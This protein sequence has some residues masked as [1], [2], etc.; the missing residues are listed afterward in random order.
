MAKGVITAETL[1]G[2]IVFPNPQELAD[3]LNFFL[4]YNQQFDAEYQEK[5]YFEHHSGSEDHFKQLLQKQAQQASSE[6]Y[7][8]LVQAPQT[9]IDGVE[10]AIIYQEGLQHC[11]KFIDRLIAAQKSKQEE[12]T[13]HSHFLIQNQIY[14]FCNYL[15]L[16]EQEKTK[17]QLVFG[18]DIKLSRDGYLKYLNMTQY[19]LNQLQHDPNQVNALLNMRMLYR[20]FCR[21]LVFY[22]QKELVI[23]V[24][25]QKILFD[26]QKVPLFHEKEAKDTVEA[27]REREAAIVLSNDVKRFFKQYKQIRSAFRKSIFLG[28]LI[29]TDQRY[30]IDYL[31]RFNIQVLANMYVFIGKHFEG[32]K[33]D[34]GRKWLANLYQTIKTLAED[35]KIAE[36]SS[37]EQNIRQIFGASFDIPPPDFQTE[38]APSDQVKPSKNVGTQIEETRSSVPKESPASSQQKKEPEAPKEIAIPNLVDALSLKDL[39]D[40][41]SSK[42]I[43]IVQDTNLLD[44]VIHNWDVRGTL[45]FPE[46]IEFARIPIQIHRPQ[47]PGLREGRIFISFAY[48]TALNLTEEHIQKL[49]EQFKQSKQIPEKYVIKLLELYPLAC[50][51]IGQLQHLVNDQRPIV[52]GAGRLLPA[53]F[54]EKCGALQKAFFEKYSYI[55]GL[56]DYWTIVEDIFYSIAR[57]LCPMGDLQLPKQ[58]D[59]QKYVAQRNEDYFAA[60]ERALMFSPH[61]KRFFKKKYSKEVETNFVN[62]KV[63]HDLF[64]LCETQ[65]INIIQR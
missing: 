27:Q 32:V 18:S 53:M 13:T 8:A 11:A 7:Y 49:L 44:Q 16:P 14:R 46:L 65:P 36:D 28:S 54:F 20:V 58:K 3:Q 17:L 40:H 31:Y 12:A 23:P 41:K 10:E 57:A 52:D 39:E 35:H 25:L 22:F 63:C 34:Y 2:D 9:Q 37:I 56:L 62:V 38:E 6:K 1:T 29:P 48:L 33:N 24:N 5:H 30:V 50:E 45:T 64:R 19:L 43:L 26:F 59:I 60:Y 51:Q 47:S 61:L 21:L 4:N 15:F 42:R 55:Q